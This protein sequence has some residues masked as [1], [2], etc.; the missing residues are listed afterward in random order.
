[1]T[2]GPAVLCH[3]DGCDPWTGAAT[4]GRTIHMA[5]GSTGT[6]KGTRAK[7]RIGKKAVVGYFSTDLSNSLHEIATAE[8]TRIQALLGE[9][10]D[11]LLVDRGRKPLRE[12]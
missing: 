9:A 8:D 7:A 3:H 5:T 4:H 6:T 11:M 10:I 12:R 2:P 1:M